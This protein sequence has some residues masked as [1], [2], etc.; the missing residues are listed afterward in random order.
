MKGGC[1]VQLYEVAG[2]DV[3]L[4]S[5]LDCHSVLRL[6]ECSGSLHRIIY[7]RERTQGTA[8]SSFSEVRIWTDPH[9]KTRVLRHLVLKVSKA[10]QFAFTFLWRVLTSFIIPYAAVCSGFYPREQF[11]F[12]ALLVAA[13]VLVA[14]ANATLFARY[15]LHEPWKW[16][17]WMEI[18]CTEKGTI[19]G[20]QG[21]E[22]SGLGTTVG[23]S[24][25]TMWRLT[26]YPILRWIIALANEA[27]L[28]VAA[29][30]WLCPVPFMFYATV[31]SALAAF[32]A[33]VA[34]FASMVAFDYGDNIMQTF[35]G[36]DI[37]K[38]S[39]LYRLRKVRNFALWFVIVTVLM[40]P[41]GTY[42]STVL[43]IFRLP[44][45][46]GRIETNIKYLL[47]FGLIKYWLWSRVWF[48]TILVS[49]PITPLEGDDASCHFKF[50]VLAL[51]TYPIS[52][53]FLVAFFYSNNPSDSLRSFV[54][55]T[56]MIIF[57]L[58]FLRIDILRYYRLSTNPRWTEDGLRIITRNSTP[59]CPPPRPFS[60]RQLMHELSDEWHKAIADPIDTFLFMSG[61]LACGL[62]PFSGWML[63][64]TI[65]CIVS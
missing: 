38:G 13:V 5:Q 54:V 15:V 2:L 48:D 7:R 41:V 43:F 26:P 55:P 52:V 51:F 44:A 29:T 50:T 65:V 18:P 58:F 39:M 8:G 19:T 25:L 30:A 46:Y 1:L 3:A 28:A 35:T 21:D 64:A 42:L 45:V 27:F 10:E 14:S 56:A 34:C 31:L 20:H 33:T 40:A 60:W 9:R 62:F 11:A 16:R 63:S 24:T 6:S 23:M 17:K 32:A 4:L 37:R 61:G 22:E 53:A 59:S 12:R 49:L 36:T 57:L 47:P